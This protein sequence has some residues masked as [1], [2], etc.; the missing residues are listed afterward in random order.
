M[1]MGLPIGE[2]VHDARAGNQIK[3]PMKTS[4]S[5]GYGKGHFVFVSC[6]V[7]PISVL[8]SNKTRRH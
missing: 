5:H 8:L 2:K 4:P 6:F 3:L 1:T 7:S